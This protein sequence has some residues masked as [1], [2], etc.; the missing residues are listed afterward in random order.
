MVNPSTK[1][2]HD[3]YIGPIIGEHGFMHETGSIQR[4]PLSSGADN[5]LPNSHHISHYNVSK[6]YC[7]VYC[8]YAVVKQV[9]RVQLASD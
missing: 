5:K 2:V 6:T 3:E 8:V 7:L 9:G 1:F 4:T